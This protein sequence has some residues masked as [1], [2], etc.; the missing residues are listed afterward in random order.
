MKLNKY[1]IISIS[2]LLEDIWDTNLISKKHLAKLLNSPITAYSKHSYNV[3]DTNRIKQL[4][5]TIP[6]NDLELTEFI[7]KLR[8]NVAQYQIQDSM[9][10]HLESITLLALIKSGIRIGY[11]DEAYL[12][13]SNISI[14]KE[15]YISPENQVLLLSSLPDKWDEP[16][17]AANV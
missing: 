3:L 15:P 7:H 12:Y 10:F 11:Y 6:Y 1:E 9:R 14:P 8:H 13:I 2:S 16:K 4:Q 5:E 17:G